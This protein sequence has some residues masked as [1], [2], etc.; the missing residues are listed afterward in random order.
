LGKTSEVRFRE[1]EQVQ[2]RVP[3]RWE[4]RQRDALDRATS[5]IYS[6]SSLSDVL[7]H[8]RSSSLDDQTAS[9]AQHRWKNFVRH[10]AW[11][12]LIFERFPECRPFEDPKHRTKDLYVPVNGSD[13]IFDLKVTRWPS[14]LDR[15][16]SLNDVARWMYSNQSQEQRFHLDNRLFV[17]GEPEGAVCRYE[18]AVATVEKFRAAREEFVFDLHVGGRSVVAGVLLVTPQ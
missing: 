1:L 12:D 9:Y 7:R 4:V 15:G 17:V 6:A 18:L 2:E 10:D 11:L 3:T 16:T 8:C 14:R 13:V 5:F